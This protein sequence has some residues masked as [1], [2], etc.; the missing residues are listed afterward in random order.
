MISMKFNDHFAFPRFTL[1]SA[2][3]F[4][5][6]ALPLAPPLTQCPRLLL[7]LCLLPCQLPS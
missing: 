6:W 3:A 1:L 5:P 2:G 7:S 4:P